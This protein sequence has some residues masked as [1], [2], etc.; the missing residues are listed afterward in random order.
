MSYPASGFESF[1]RNPISQVSKFLNHNHS[2]NYM[3]FNLSGRK[4][5]YNK[6]NKM[7]SI[8][9]KVIEF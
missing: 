5:D 3:V 8:I 9:Y 2:I 6:F 7:V 4:Y 1:Y